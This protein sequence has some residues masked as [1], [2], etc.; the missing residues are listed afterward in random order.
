MAF[1]EW[2]I[3]TVVLIALII[4]CRLLWAWL[5]LKSHAHVEPVEVAD[6]SIASEMNQLV[7]DIATLAGVATPPVFIRRAA[8]PNAFV[9]ATV[10]RP[11]IYL[12]DELLEQCNASA[13]PLNMLT[14]V[15]SH[16]ISH[17]RRGDGL[18]LG[19]LTWLSH[20]FTGTGMPRLAATCTQRIAGI[21][22]QADIEVDQLMQQLVG[23]D[24]ESCK[25]T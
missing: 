11:E 5:R 7:A 23:Q 22:Q 10:L 1:I 25:S 12:T 4:V 18:W 3:L 6:P 16:E 2:A 19:L 21:E 8:L 20:I 13:N 14:R 24:K 9:V 17:I 15:L